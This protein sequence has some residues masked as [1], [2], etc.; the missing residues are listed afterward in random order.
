MKILDTLAFI[1][2]PMMFILGF[3]AIIILSVVSY[4]EKEFQVLALASAL[5]T[6]VLGWYITRY[7]AKSKGKSIVY[8]LLD[9]F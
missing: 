9:L 7:A 2:G 5:V 8:I 4:N 1:I 6:T 3:G